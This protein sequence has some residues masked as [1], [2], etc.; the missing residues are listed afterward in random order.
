[1]LECCDAVEDLEGTGG[2]CADLAQ[3]TRDPQTCREI[4]RTIGYMLEERDEP[5]PESC[6]L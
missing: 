3:D 1:M 5:M 4:L 6:Q 2:A